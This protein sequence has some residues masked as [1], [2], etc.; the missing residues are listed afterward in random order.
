[1]EISRRHLLGAGA[2]LIAAPA[3]AQIKVLNPFGG[4]S[5]SVINPFSTQQGSVSALTTSTTS[6]ASKFASTLVNGYTPKFVSW[7]GHSWSVDTG[8]TWNQ[9]MDYS[10]RTTSDKCRF[11]LHNTVD[12]RGQMDPSYKRRAEIHDPKHP[13]QNGVVYWHAFTFLDFAWAS[14]PNSGPGT[15]MQMHWPSGASPA[16]AFRR[17]QNG[18]LCITTR[19]DTTGNTQRYKGPLSFGAPHDFVYRFKLD[20]SN[21]SLDVWVDGNHILSLTGVPIGSK[22]ENGCY[23]GI[24]PY[25]GSGTSNVIVQEYANIASF[26]STTSLTSRIT[27]R[28]S[29]PSA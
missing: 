6:D 29:W 24:G 14:M 11:E 17:L 3:A 5:P 27:S 7:L 22:T 15:I 23:L 20:G 1:M 2:G 19:G 12:D 25:Y 28:P 8:S 10:W 13:F 21:G 4:S 18:N 16:F 26:P 9:N